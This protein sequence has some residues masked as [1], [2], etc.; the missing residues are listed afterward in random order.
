MAEKK[1]VPRTKL[2]KKKVVQDVNPMD[3][4][5]VPEA[6]KEEKDTAPS[7]DFE[8]NVAKAERMLN[9]M[10]SEHEFTA[11]AKTMLSDLR[12][13]LYDNCQLKIEGD[14]ESGLFAEGIRSGVDVPSACQSAARLEYVLSSLADGKYSRSIYEKVKKE[15]MEIRKA[16]GD[17]MADNREKKKK[18]T[19]PL[20]DVEMD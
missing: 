19:N 8:S 5:D 12:H 2:S 7:Y 13:W 15:E 10:M 4:F 14:A 6:P 11:P 20:F 17:Y 3:A 1:F 16:M 18:K 9:E